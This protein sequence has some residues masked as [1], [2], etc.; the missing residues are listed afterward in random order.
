MLQNKALLK[1][2]KNL[3]AFS[4]GADSTALL[5]LL[6]ENE[7]YFD[8]AIVDYGLRLASKEEVAYAKS[9]AQKYNF[10]CHLFEAPQIE[11][12][13]EANAR[14]F[15]YKFFESL[16]KEHAYKN[17]LTAHHLGDRF[18]WLLMQFCKGA[19]CYELSGMRGVESRDGY[20]LLR[21]LLHLDK[22]ELLQ[23]LASKKIHYFE[24][25]S[26]Q[27]EKYKRNEFRHNYAT[28][29]LDKYRSGIAKSFEYID[30][31]VN[32]LVTNIEVKTLS[33]LA[34]FECSG[35]KRSDIIAIDKYLKS[36]NHLITAHEKELLY[37]EKTVVLGRKYVVSQMQLYVFIAPYV[38]AKK[39][40]KS[41]KEQ[42]RRLRVDPKLRAYLSSDSGSGVVA[43]V[44]GLLA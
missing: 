43:L 32:S 23:Y 7:I 28:P 19:G 20:T 18:E 15:R 36:Q 25:E 12:N 33:A 31:D 26:N 39:M 10:T 2:S 4:G 42:M 17:L 29:L 9:L 11:K 24:D 35:S 27:D 40:Q 37:R 34:Y 44:S 38:K 14:V 30:A 8:I 13:F 16:I 6:L 5:F 22:Q 21:P 3:L 41:F 1:K